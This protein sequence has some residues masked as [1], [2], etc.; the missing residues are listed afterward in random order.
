M[1]L[2][3]LC[4]TRP[5]QCTLNSNSPAFPPTH[6]T[7]TTLAFNFRVTFHRRSTLSFSIFLCCLLDFKRGNFRGYLLK[8]R[9][10]H[11]LPNMII[12]GLNFSCGTKTALR[13]PWTGASSVLFFTTP[14]ASPA[15]IRC[16]AVCRHMAEAKAAVAPVRH[17]FLVDPAG[18]LPD[19]NVGRLE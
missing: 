8:S 6:D 9:A 19:L 4:G 7:V 15:S 16:P 2:R 11:C 1:H 14:P 3:T 13:F 12:P 17:R 10:T 5:K 18:D